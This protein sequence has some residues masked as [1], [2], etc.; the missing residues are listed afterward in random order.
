M[1]LSRAAFSLATCASLLGIVAWIMLLDTGDPG[2][3]VSAV[4]SP[5]SSV[6]GYT[7][8]FIARGD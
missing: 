4:L 1:T 5:I 3:L 7:L 2:W 8:A 6:G